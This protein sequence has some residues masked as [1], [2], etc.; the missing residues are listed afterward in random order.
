MHL[1][2]LGVDLLH[3][4]SWSEV[5]ER[6]FGLAVAFSV[7]V[8]PI[9]LVHYRIW[10]SRWTVCLETWVRCDVGPV[11][12]FLDRPRKRPPFVE[13][14]E[15]R[16]LFCGH[17]WHFA[18]RR[19]LDGAR[20]AFARCNRSLCIKVLLSKVLFVAFDFAV[21]CESTFDLL[22]LVVVLCDSEQIPLD[23]IFGRQLRSQWCS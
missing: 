14:L 7:V 2:M 16:L 15:G 3:G 9:V 12:Y 6:S 20:G 22:R 19:A 11:N 10:H 4:I 13:F 18:R 23:I 1:I 21:L 8:V 5:G 17:L